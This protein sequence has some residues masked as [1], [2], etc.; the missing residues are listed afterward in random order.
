MEFVEHNDGDTFAIGDAQVT[1]RQLNHPTVTG[2]FRIE[3]NGRSLA[4]ISDADIYGETLFAQELAVDGEAEARQQILQGTREL[5]HG[6]GLLVCDTFFL[7]DE[8]R[9]DFGHSSVDDG[10][11]LAAETEAKRVA[12]YHHRPAREDAD[13]DDIV[14]RYQRRVGSKTEI[15]GSREGRGITL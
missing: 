14:E 12:L 5:S 7:P 11:R 2:G 13:L 15:I 3:A 1:C 10:L 8:Y 9:P 4:Y 6:A